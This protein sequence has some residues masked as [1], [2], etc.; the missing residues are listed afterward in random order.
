MVA[1]LCR[2]ITSVHD[3]DRHRFFAPGTKWWLASPHNKASKNAVTLE[4][5]LGVEDGTLTSLFG[6]KWK[7]KVEKLVFPF[8]DF[9]IRSFDG[10]SYISVKVSEFQDY[11]DDSISPLD[12]GAIVNSVDNCRAVNNLTRE[13]DITISLLKVKL[14]SI[15]DD[16]KSNIEQPCFTNKNPSN[17]S[18]INELAFART[19]PLLASTVVVTQDHPPRRNEA[20]GGI[21]KD[22]ES[23]E[24]RLAFTTPPFYTTG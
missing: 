6:R 15:E 20:N 3:R 10:A 19:L 22:D 24:Y 16:K 2:L 14:Q 9:D 4:S 13:L 1:R 12:P 23:V 17:I 5:Q 8:I 11:G 7:A 18:E 21:L